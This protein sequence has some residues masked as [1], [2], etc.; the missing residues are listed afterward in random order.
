M[1]NILDRKYLPIY[2]LIASVITPLFFRNDMFLLNMAIMSGIYIILT[3]S[4]RLVFLTGIWHV[5]QAAFYSLGAY[6]LVLMMEN[7]GTSFWLTLPMVG[8]LGFFVAV[9][10]GF[11]TLR[12]RGIYFCILSISL[13]E[14]FRLTYMITRTASERIMRAQPPAPIS[15]G[16]LVNID[17]A[18]SRLAY[19]FLTLVIV[20]ITLVILN[21]LEKSEFGRILRAIEKNELLVSSVGINA[22][23]YKVAAFA[24]CSFFAAVAGGLFASYNV[25]ITRTS[26]SG[27]LSMIFVVDM[28]V[29]GMGSIYGPVIG[30]IFLTVL[31][32]YLP[33]DPI[34]I[35]IVY[36]T[37]LI[38]IVS[39]LPEGLISIPSRLTQLYERLRRRNEAVIDGRL[40]G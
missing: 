4:L 22:L 34:E 17:F 16:G 12:V 5:G 25:V 2:V 13:A 7:W 23:N 10:I 21:R 24:I 37:M 32:E 15:L 39:I 8:I 35:K 30:T 11:I 6:G 36:G 38:I 18:S 29:G 27:W 20:V 9:I 33:L 1:T 28:V 14:V 19:Y 31:P 40:P 26:F 3:T